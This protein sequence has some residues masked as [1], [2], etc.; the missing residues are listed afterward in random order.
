MLRIL[1]EHTAAAISY[2]L[3]TTDDRT[4][5]VY[6]LG[7]GTFDVSLLQIEGGVFEVLAANGHSHLG[8]EDFDRQ[9]VDHFLKEI[10]RRH[11]VDLTKDKKAIQR[12]RTEAERAK[13]ALS[14]RTKRMILRSV[15]MIRKL[16]Q[17]FEKSN[18]LA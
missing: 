5:L 8:G 13:R 4:V 3:D 18:L 16:K 17:D 11:N 9:I 10:R 12:L 1:N 7:G 6:D 2:G 15:Q 14:R